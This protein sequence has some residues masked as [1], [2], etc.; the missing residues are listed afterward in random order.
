V[1]Y[2]F[3][4]IIISIKKERGGSWMAFRSQPA[5]EMLS[6]YG[7]AILIMALAL[8]LLT[9]FSISKPPEQLIGSS[10]NIQPE[11]I[12]TQT[13]M[14]SSNATS[15]ARFI[16][17]LTNNLGSPISFNPLSINLTVLGSSPWSGLSYTGSCKPYVVSV[18]AQAVC[19]VQITGNS[20]KPKAGVVFVDQFSLNYSLCTSVNVGCSGTYK[21]TG[22][23]QQAIGAA[24]FRIWYLTI[25]GSIG[26]KRNIIV[27]LINSQSSN[28]PA[29]FQQQITFNPLLY[30][31]YEAN[32]LGNIRFYQGPIGTNELYS[33]CES[34][35]TSSSTNAI[36]WINLPSGIGAS[37]NVLVNMSFGANSVEY[38]G[39][40]AGE[41]PQLTCSNANTMI[42]GAGKTYG[43]FDNGASVFPA[44]YTGFPGTSTPSGWSW[45]TS[46]PNA[47]FTA[48]GLYIIGNTAEGISLSQYSANEAGNVLE[49]YT[50]MAGAPGQDD[51]MF[52]ADNSYLWNGGPEWTPLSSGAGVADMDFY[53]CGCDLGGLSASQSAFHVFSIYWP[54]STSATFYYDYGA[55]GTITYGSMPTGSSGVG[56]EIWAQGPSNTLTSYWVRARAEPPNG[57]MPTASLGAGLGGPDVYINGVEYPTPSVALLESGNYIIYTNSLVSGS[58]FVNWIL[59][60]N[61]PPT[62]IASNTLLQTTLNLA[63]NATLTANW[64][65]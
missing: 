57:V 19:I 18:G 28:T 21:S 16:M 11:I 20:Y 30:A 41:A 23:S 34:G 12:C 17:T 7:W 15:N 55:P 58:T 48:N 53:F 3:I 31:P 54:G 13:A 8:S 33:W 47:G 37:S 62:S 49:S 51:M 63:S 64:I 5:I 50:S 14:Y 35:C 44:L 22:Y 10:C 52:G 29:P 6:V 65:V 60:G 59:T 61:T 25:P 43:Q 9:I 2:L 38:D 1:R 42:C 26:S 32:D 46:Y 56:Y 40:Y 24:N 27:T 39:V 36:F 4:S 45:Y